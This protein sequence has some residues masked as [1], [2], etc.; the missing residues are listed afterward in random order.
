MSGGF[1]ALKA[2]L[3]R[4]HRKALSPK[5]Q[6]RM[7]LR[8]G[9]LAALLLA[10]FNLQPQSTALQQVQ[11]RGRLV[12]TGISGPTTFYQ[13]SAGARGLQYELAR[14]FAED[15]GVKLVLEDAGSTN[16]V[17]NGIRRNQTDIAITGLASDDPRLARLRTAAPYMAVSEQLI[18]RLDR[19]LPQNFDAIG[20]A[21]I[22]VLA[23]SSE[24]QRLKTL[25]RWRPDIA[26]I[27]FDGLDP[28]ALMERVD[29]GELD[30]VAL[31]S[32][33]F[34]ARRALYP[35]I[36]VALNLQ[37]NSE[38]AWAFLKTRDQSLF[39]AAQAFLARK[40]ADGTLGRLVAFYSQGETFDPYSV[41]S[42]QRDIAQR[43]PRYQELFEKNAE[44][45]HMD[46]RLLAAIAYQESRWQPMAVSPTGVQ[47]MMMLTAN[48]AQHMGVEDRTNV[49]QSIRGGA[50]YYQMILNSLPPSVQEPDRTWMALAAYNMGP[51]HIDRARA[52]AQKAGDDADKWMVV[53]RHLRDMAQQARRN[54]RN[55]PVGQALIYVQQV[56]RYYD[57]LL[58]ATSGSGDDQRVAMNTSRQITR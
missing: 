9:V 53:S 38:L 23:S 50:A 6:P 15:L 26:I 3:A 58:L 27:E 21:R 13:T 11:E 20:S 12:V 49:P 29:N 48:T 40:Q 4:V 16:A 2:R 57:A 36:G 25:A 45:H 17:L 19:P 8:A 24:A 7:L 44:K 22:G 32:N 34:D 5:A 55:I 52:A 14:L 18:Q 33:E 30:Y 42:F 51:A 1:M 41:R 47:G 56:R 35:N 43:L 39:R 46:W 10:L 37:D 31:N 54:G 28:L